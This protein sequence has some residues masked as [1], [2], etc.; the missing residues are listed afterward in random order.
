MTR[1]QF[2]FQYEADSYEHASQNNYMRRT[3]TPE[4]KKAELESPDTNSAL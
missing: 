1:L 3:K 4:R 2:H